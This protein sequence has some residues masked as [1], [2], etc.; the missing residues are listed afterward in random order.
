M[1]LLSRISRINLT[2]L[3]LAED[4]SRPLLDGRDDLGVAL[5]SVARSRVAA[6]KPLH[7]AALVPP[8]GHSKHHAAAH[9]LAH[10]LHSAQ[11]HERLGS[12]L[13][14]VVVIHGA[15]DVDVGI[16]EHLAVLHVFA[17]D[18]SKRAILGGELGDDGEG[19]VGVDS[20]GRG[21]EV[22]RTGLV[23]V[24]A[25]AV[26]VAHACC[27]ALIACAAVETGL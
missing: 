2:P 4:N 16:L 25:A 10:T 11:V 22:L 17:E 13:A 7:E 9:A 6:I 3:D 5:S 18:G 15:C 14:A 21:I 24:A 26:L 8:N 27:A 19:L 12:V 1:G 23:R 20:A